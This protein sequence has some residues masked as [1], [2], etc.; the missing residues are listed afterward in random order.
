MLKTLVYIK[1]VQD[2]LMQDNLR[3]GSAG[4]IFL[5]IQSICYIY[6]ERKLNISI[7]IR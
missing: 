7:Y 5:V 4:P 6:F 1:L 3:P 2:Q